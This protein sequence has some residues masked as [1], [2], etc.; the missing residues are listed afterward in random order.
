MCSVGLIDYYYGANDAI[1]TM[2]LIL[3]FELN[4]SPLVPKPF[5]GWRSIESFGDWA[6]RELFHC[7]FCPI[8]YAMSICSIHICSRNDESLYH[9]FFFLFFFFSAPRK[10]CH[11]C[12]PHSRF[13]LDHAVLPSIIPTPYYATARI[14][15]SWLR[16]RSIAED[17]S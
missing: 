11:W 8:L 10:R 15:A 1:P 5:L 16:H 17:Y 3:W 7:V 14:F 6:W 4:L 13:L 9:L 2:I 12:H